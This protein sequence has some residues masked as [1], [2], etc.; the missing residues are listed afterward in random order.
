MKSRFFTLVLSAILLVG[1]SSL[2]AA[3]SQ[4]K[5]LVNPE[6]LPP[7]LSGPYR[8]QVGDILEIRFFKSTQ[9]NQS[10]TV[11]P[12]G[13]IYMPLIGKVHVFDRTVTEITDDLNERYAAEVV[14]P[15]V[16]VNVREFSG[17]RF[18]VGGEVLAPGMR[19][20]RGDLTVVKAIMEAGGFHTTAALSTVVLIRNGDND[21]PVGTKINVKDILHKGKF[22]R[23]V[24]LEPSDIIFVPRSKVANVNLFVEQFIRNNIPIP[25]SLGFGV[26]TT[27]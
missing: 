25:I 9:L 22:D 26:W 3:Q 12:D 27:K 21:Q 2:Y 16:T 13:D 15:Q 7:A 1:L 17:L 18:Y 14:E 5:S 24:A 23:D 6:E 20:Y 11:G 4:E 8:V 19:P 10:L